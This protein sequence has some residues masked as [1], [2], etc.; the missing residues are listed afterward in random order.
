MKRIALAISLIFSFSAIVVL[1]SSSTSDAQV[2][3]VK[4]RNRKARRNANVAP[5]SYQKPKKEGQMKVNT[6]SPTTFVVVKDMGDHQLIL[7]Y[8]ID[9]K[10]K[11]SQSDKKKFFY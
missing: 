11:V 6:L 7:V 1:S 4:H 3:M 5:V 2:K 8:E 9:D 10:G